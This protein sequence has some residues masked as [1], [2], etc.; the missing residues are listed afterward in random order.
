[1]IGIRRVGVCSKTGSCTERAEAPQEIFPSPSIAHRFPSRLLRRFSPE[2]T[3][4]ARVSLTTPCYSFPHQHP[5][6]L[7]IRLDF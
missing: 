6:T 3:P 4:H 5:S 2:H 7:H 1:M